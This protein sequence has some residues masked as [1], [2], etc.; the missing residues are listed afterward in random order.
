MIVGFRH[1][2]SCHRERGW[3]H[4]D[5]YQTVGDDFARDYRGLNDEGGEDPI[6]AVWQRKGDKVRLFWAAEGGK[7]T[8]EPGFD[9]HLAPDPTPL[10]TILDW[11]LGVRGSDWY[12]KLEY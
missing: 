11:T 6:V 8:A 5:F 10:W 1:N 4:L 3:T 12:P 9:P 2:F 7:E